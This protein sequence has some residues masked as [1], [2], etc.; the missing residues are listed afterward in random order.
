MLTLEDTHRN[1][2]ESTRHWS[3]GKAPSKRNILS[4]VLLFVAS[5]HQMLEGIVD[6]MKHDFLSMEVSVPVWNSAPKAQGATAP[7]TY[8]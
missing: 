6:N 1:E 5:A 4:E 2:N 3:W 8:I 7:G